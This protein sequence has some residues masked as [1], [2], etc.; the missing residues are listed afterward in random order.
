MNKYKIWSLFWLRQRK[1]GTVRNNRENLFGTVCSKKK[2]GTVRNNLA[3]LF[4]TEFFRVFGEFL[5]KNSEQRVRNKARL[6]FRTKLSQCS[7]FISFSVPNSC[8]AKYW[9]RNSRPAMLKVSS[10]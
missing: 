10:V 2:L 4:G 1:L 8:S 7:E 9:R 5:I 3:N 6:M